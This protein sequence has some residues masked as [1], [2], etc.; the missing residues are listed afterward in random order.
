MSAGGFL[1]RLQRRLAPLL[2]GAGPKTA[3][4][5]TS[6]VP[7][8]FEIGRFLAAGPD[9]TG[10]D[11][12]LAPHCDDICFSLGAH[13]RRRQSG[14]LLTVFP[15]GGYIA[16]SGCS[17][18]EITTIRLAEDAAFARA[19]GLTNCFLEIEGASVLGRDPFDLAWAETNAERIE[20]KLIGAVVGI[21]ARRRAAER[22]W[23]F[24]PAGIGG[25]VDH[26]AVRTVVSRNIERL[27]A[28]Y[29]V[30]FYEDLHYASAEAARAAGVEA[31]LGAHP[32]APLSRYVL[33][34]GENL[35][36]KIGFLRLYPSQFQELPES[37]A[38]FTPFAPPDTPPH[39]AVWS[40]EPAGPG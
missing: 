27:G 6:A 24:C 35:D 4:A 12:Y 33:P 29:R 23:L 26:A 25:H 18:E 17:K 5:D 30:G 2:G 10:L 34:V 31:L 13:A 9:T 40:A 14:L 32:G 22:P 3:A 38:G 1:A 11:V 37:I 7:S 39:E 36:A 28:A 21:A 15:V 8:G 19:S 20:A 16:A